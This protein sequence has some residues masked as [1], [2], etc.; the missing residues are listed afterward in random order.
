MV[1]LVANSQGLT[2]GISPLG[3]TTQDIPQSLLYQSRSN[4]AVILQNPQAG[5]YAVVLTGLHNGS[6]ELSVS[7]T[8]FAHQHAQ[9]VVKGTIMRGQTISYQV[10]LSSVNGEPQTPS[11]ALALRL[12]ENGCDGVY[13][14]VKLKGD[15]RVSDGQNC[16]FS[17]GRILG[18]VLIDGGSLTA[19]RHHSG[20]ECT[21]AGR[22]ILKP[23]IHHC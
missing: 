19:K 14:E 4:P 5:N 3:K 7:E 21:G 6:Y 13:Y 22:R 18:H 11:V 23:S 10:N 15:L 16:T 9:Q 20:W 1:I 12:S 2:A 17:S 8:G